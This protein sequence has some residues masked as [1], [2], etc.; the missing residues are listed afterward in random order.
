MQT[1]PTT[2]MI[3]TLPIDAEIVNSCVY[4]LVKQKELFFYWCWILLHNVGSMTHNWDKGF[5]KR[6]LVSLP[7]KTYLH[8][9]PL[10]CRSN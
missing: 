2:A 8:F 10:N 4:Q 3:C 9:I 7:A 6:E 5:Y 1:T